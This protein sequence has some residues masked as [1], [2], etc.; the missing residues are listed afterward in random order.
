MEQSKAGNRGQTK[1]REGLVVSSKMEKTV[2]VAV[3]RQVRNPFYGKYVR[4]T[5]RYMAH[6]ENKV[7]KEGDLVRIEETRPM[8]RHKRWKVAEVLSKAE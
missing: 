4:K 7:C 8:S 6:D 5:S 3:V 1:V 2:V